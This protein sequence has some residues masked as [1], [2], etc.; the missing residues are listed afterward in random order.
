M[1]HN[2]ATLPCESGLQEH[3]VGILFLTLGL[4]IKKLFKVVKIKQNLIMFNDLVPKVFNFIKQLIFSSRTLPITLL[5]TIVYLERL[6]YAL[7]SNARANIDTYQRIFCAS[8][9]LATKYLHDSSMKNKWWA[10]LTGTYSLNEVNQMEQHMLMLLSYDL[11][12]SPKEITKIIYENP[13]AYWF[14]SNSNQ[15]Y[16]T[17]SNWYSW[18]SDNNNNRQICKDESSMKIGSDELQLPLTPDS[19]TQVPLSPIYGDIHNLLFGNQLVP[20]DSTLIDIYQ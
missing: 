11:S 9:I 7:P 17:W 5:C 10:H 14:I 20:G 13:Q 15:I 18:H 1:L 8:L 4:T 16:N 6:Q 2:V 3:L 19:L 12:T